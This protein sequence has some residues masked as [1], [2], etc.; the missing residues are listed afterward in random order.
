[1]WLAGTLDFY[2]INLNFRPK[3]LTPHGPLQGQIC[4]ASTAIQLL[5]QD[6]TGTKFTRLGLDP[7]GHH[8]RLLL[9]QQRVLCLL[10]KPQRPPPSLARRDKSTLQRQRLR[11][12]SPGALIRGAAEA[13]RTARQQDEER[14]QDEV[15]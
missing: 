3:T 13:L 5:F 15:A 10:L 6:A 12:R 1:M 7:S 4:Q 14:R 9:H 11:W 2:S 8:R